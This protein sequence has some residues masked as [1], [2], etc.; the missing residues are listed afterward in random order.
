MQP[1][2]GYSPKYK[3]TVWQVV[4]WAALG[5]PLTPAIERACSYVLEHS[6]LPDGRFSAYKTAQGAVPCLGG[7]LVRA[8]MQLGMEDTRIADSL[9]SLALQVPRHGFRCRFN[10]G[11]AG[12][13]PPKRMEAGLPCAW[14][15]I[16]VLGA[17]AQEDSAHRSPN[18]PP[19][20]AWS[21][22]LPVQCPHRICP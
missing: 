22:R 3:A 15:A 9:E 13:P 14:G 20:P 8:L 11:E 10:V 21:L 19:A 2:V 1:G 7:N 5:G 6:R 17:F 12:Q 4:F 16:K 18:A